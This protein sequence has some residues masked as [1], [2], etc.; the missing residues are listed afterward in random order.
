VTEDGANVASVTVPVNG[1]PAAPVADTTAPVLTLG[2]AASITLAVGT[3]FV[4]PGATAT[5]NVSGNLTASIVK[6]GSVNHLALGTYTITYNVSDAA[7][8]AAAPVTRT[9]TVTDTVKPV[10]TLTGSASI[11]IK[12]YS[13]YTDA[14]ATA[15][16]NYDGNLTASITK[17][18]TVKTGTLGTYTV[19]YNVKDSSNNAATQVTRTVKVVR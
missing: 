12:R 2:G 3:A 13:T 6:S 15:T 14:G 8:N 17:V 10:I 11:S 4:D 16:D 1:T 9:V 7:G 5:D 18:S 19:K